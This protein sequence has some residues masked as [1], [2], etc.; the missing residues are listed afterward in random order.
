MSEGNLKETPKITTILKEKDP[1]C[2][3]TGKRL[4]QLNKERKLRKEQQME[5]DENKSY[6]NY[7]LILNFVGVAVAVV[8]LY[9]ASKKPSSSA[10]VTVISND[11]PQV[12]A[13]L[14]NKLVKEEKRQKVL[15]TL[16]ELLLYIDGTA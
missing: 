2:A 15:D 9:Y 7:G 4:A 13:K 8:S 11:K 10:D 16:E 1:K 6:I 14:A 5:I 12:A 3:E